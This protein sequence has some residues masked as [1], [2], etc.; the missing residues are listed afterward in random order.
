MQS[1]TRASDNQRTNFGGWKRK[2]T[3]T[4]KT[5]QEIDAGQVLAGVPEGGFTQTE[6]K[7]E[8]EVDENTE[9]WEKVEGRSKQNQT[10]VSA[11]EAEQQQ[12]I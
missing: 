4:V 6:A 11:R 9:A 5:R 2:I 10:T 8:G 3:K 12:Q 7:G 1:F